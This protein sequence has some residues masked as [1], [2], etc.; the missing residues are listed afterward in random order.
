MNIKN[1]FIPMLDVN[2]I[3]ELPDNRDNE[4]A[5]CQYNNSESSLK[6]NNIFKKNDVCTFDPYF[7][8]PYFSSPQYPIFPMLY[9]TKHLLISH[10]SPLMIPSFDPSPVH[11][12]DT[13][14]VIKSGY[15]NDSNKI[16][17]EDNK[18]YAFIDKNDYYLIKMEQ[19]LQK[20]MN[21]EYLKNVTSGAS[22]CSYIEEKNYKPKD[23]HTNIYQA[24]GLFIP[25][26]TL[27][28]QPHLPLSPFLTYTPLISNPLLPLL[29]PYMP[30]PFL[31]NS[32]SLTHNYYDNMNNIDEI[33][34]RQ[35]LA[36]IL[37]N[38]HREKL[39]ENDI[40]EKDDVNE[41]IIENDI[42]NN[43]IYVKP[44]IESA[45]YDEPL[46]KR[47]RVISISKDEDYD[48][49]SDTAKIEIDKIIKKNVLGNVDLRSFI[50]LQNGETKLVENL[51][52]Q[53]FLK[54]SGSSPDFDIAIGRV[55]TIKTIDL[56]MTKILFAINGIANNQDTDLNNMEK[57]SNFSN[58]SDH[59]KMTHMLVQKSH[60]FFVQDTKEKQ[61]GW[62]SVSPKDSL[63]E[64][65]LLCRQLLPCDNCLVIL[66]KNKNLFSDPL[67]K[68]VNPSPNLITNNSFKTF[69]SGG[70]NLE[71]HEKFRPLFLPPSSTFISRSRIS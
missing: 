69:L 15:I 30:A 38:D 68:C 6:F 44:K 7:S 41:N 42:K 2:F 46:H 14:N 65:G 37:N 32:Y 52:T 40:L 18:N 62:S 48:I 19:D 61:G 63:K 51:K 10:P 36:T 45:L 1:Q 26:L 23:E 12:I 5:T 47:M 25:Q 67:S 64:F 21:S 11:Y 35:E 55:I 57:F 71:N 24:L 13:R 66:A 33:K 22:E 28:L 49:Q 53:D 4:E 50:Q 43:N 20:S 16:N 17:I 70:C 27:N 29:S 58:G 8:L 59:K 9:P 60:L 39:N 3:K 31:K 54:S 34:C 56:K